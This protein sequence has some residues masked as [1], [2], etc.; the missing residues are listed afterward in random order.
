MKALLVDLDDTLLGAATSGGRVETW[1]GA[2][3][4]RR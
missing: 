3:G 1:V 2:V 4:E